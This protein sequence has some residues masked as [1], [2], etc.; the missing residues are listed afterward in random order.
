MNTSDKY[1]SQISSRQE[2]YDAITREDNYA[3][4]WAGPAGSRKADAYVS[5]RTGKPFTEMEWI[6]F[7]EKY[8]NEAKL[9][10]ANYI[11]DMNVVNIR[12][13]KAASLLISALTTSATPEDLQKI[14]G[15]S[16]SKFP[17]M[18]GGLCDLKKDREVYPKTPVGDCA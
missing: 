6:T 13:L 7:A 4:G 8:L 10:Y 12:M 5:A 2:V 3:Q 9:A 1:P 16:S 15:V 14:G 17:I 11:K 18:T